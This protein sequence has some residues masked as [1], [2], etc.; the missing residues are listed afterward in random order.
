VKDSDPGDR[1]TPH[2]G[3]MRGG[4]WMHGP[5]QC[6]A[7]TRLISDDMFGGAGFRIALT[8]SRE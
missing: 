8:T 3:A 6:R 1:A 4:G 7:A 2:D 5:E